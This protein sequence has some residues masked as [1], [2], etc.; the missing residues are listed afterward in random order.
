M[1]HLKKNN[2]KIK[3][4]CLV[5]GVAANKKIS[6]SLNKLIKEYNCKL[7]TPPKK[8]CGDNA[9]IIANVCLNHYKLN[10]KPDLDFKANPRLVI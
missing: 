8:L 10:I 1:N 3:D 5:G 4:V 2:Y 7:I 6:L 9:V